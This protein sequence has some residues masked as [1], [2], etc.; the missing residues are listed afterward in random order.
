MR[1]A[2]AALILVLV[3]LVSGAA[4]SPATPSQTEA[5]SALA[6]ARGDVQASPKA[7][8]P[9]PGRP[10]IESLGRAPPR[11]SVGQATEPLR[12]VPIQ[13]EKQ[14]PSHAQSQA[15]SHAQSEVQN[16][17]P[18]EPPPP[19]PPSPLRGPVQAAPP[20]AAP[21]SPADD[22][23]YSFHQVDGKFL[24]LDSHT[25]QVA[26]CQ[27]SAT[28]WLCQALPDERAALESEIGRLQRENAALKQSLLARGLDLPGGV[29]PDAPAA[30]D[31]APAAKAPDQ[32]PAPKQPNMA[33]F[34]RAIAFMKDVW[35]R[36]VEMMADLQRDIQRK[37]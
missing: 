12:P 19:R 21:S 1:H 32:A 25:G 13:P 18:S 26:Q 33:E 14:T 23:R 11:E 37:S 29:K 8:R 10:M 16:R 24:R 34:D 28:G 22:R 36:L 35:R 15:Q 9:A 30:G 3:A 20:V 27:R 31:K 17:T 2:T 4:G 6:P 7:E 5:Q